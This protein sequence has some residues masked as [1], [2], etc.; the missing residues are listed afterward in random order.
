LAWIVIVALVV[1]LAIVSCLA[2]F[3]GTLRTIMADILVAALTE[4]TALLWS[5]TPVLGQVFVR[6]SLAAG[7]ALAV[8]GIVLNHMADDR[9]HR[10]GRF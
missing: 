3:G 10:S 5:R 4:G 9:A 2:W 1:G 6:W 7:T 8:V